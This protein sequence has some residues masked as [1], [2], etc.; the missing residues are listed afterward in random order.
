MDLSILKTMCAIHSP[1]GNEVA[2]KEFLLDYIKKES[3]N[4]KHKPKVIHG[5]GFQD[6]VMLV[7]GKPRTAIFAHTD[8][9]GFTVRYGKQLVKIGGPG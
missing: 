8:S 9:I 3:K 6:N 2:M 5:K 7:F 1:S 4:W